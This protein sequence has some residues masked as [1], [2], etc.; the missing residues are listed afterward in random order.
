[1]IIGLSACGFKAPV[2]SDFNELDTTKFHGGL[3]GDG[4][5]LVLYEGVIDDAVMGAVLTA[6]DGTSVTLSEY[7]IVNNP[8][9]NSLIIFNEYKAQKDDKVSLTLDKEGF[10]QLSFVVTVEY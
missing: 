4:Y 8:D 9:G 1:M 6:D 10:E 7:M 5:F 3:S 2:I